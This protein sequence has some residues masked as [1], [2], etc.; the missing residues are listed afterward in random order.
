MSGSGGRNQ[1]VRHIRARN[2]CCGSVTVQQFTRPGGGRRITRTRIP[3]G[4]PCGRDLGLGAC[5]DHDAEV[6]A[7]ELLAERKQGHEKDDPCTSL[8][9]P[10]CDHGKREADE[11]ERRAGEHEAE[12]TGPRPS[13][14]H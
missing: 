3:R 10:P 9:D 8:P 11:R 5:P 14:R 12:G 7:G 1:S 6:E 13:D 4:L 2:R